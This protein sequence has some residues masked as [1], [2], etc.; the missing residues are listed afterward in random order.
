VA[1]LMGFDNKSQEFHD[2]LLKLLRIRNRLF[3]VTPHS[4]SLDLKTAVDE[5]NLSRCSSLTS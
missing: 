1:W 3:V 5:Q 4:R 2:A